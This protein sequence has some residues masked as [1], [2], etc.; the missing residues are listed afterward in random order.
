MKPKEAQGLVKTFEGTLATYFA[1]LVQDEVV[2]GST[3]APLSTHNKIKPFLQDYTSVLHIRPVI[4]AALG[5]PLSLEEVLVLLQ[6]TIEKSRNKSIGWIPALPVEEAAPAAAEVVPPAAEEEAA[7]PQTTPV[8]VSAEEAG[9]GGLDLNSLDKKSKDR[10]AVKAEAVSYVSTY[11]ALY[12]VTESTTKGS[13]DIHPFCDLQI[14]TFL[15]NTVL[16][17]LSQAIIEVMRKQ[18]E[19]PIMHVAD[20]LAKVSEKNQTEALENARTKFYE[21]LRS[22]S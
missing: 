5:Q 16:P 15:S 8:Q 1:A 13:Y 22:T 12:E 9:K 2:E 20:F 19:D 4:S 21:L 3:G 10:L 14:S 11:C 18:P 17:V 6:R 7:V